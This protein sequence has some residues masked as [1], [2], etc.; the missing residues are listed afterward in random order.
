MNQWG[1]L[2]GLSSKHTGLLCHLS[3]SSVTQSCLTLCNPMDCS[4]PGL[5]VYHHLSAF[6]QTHVHWV[7]Y[8]VQP[9]LPLSSTSLP[10]LNL[11]QHQDLF[12]WVSSLNQVVNVIQLQHQSLQWIFG[13]DFL[14]DGL[15]GSPCHP[16]DSQE[17][18]LIPQFKSIKYSVL[19]FLYSPTHIDAWL[20][21][22]T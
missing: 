7:C 9:S 13:T 11:S 8:A 5:P 1:F 15:V 14:Q 21:E 2:A 12:K 3:V 20:L 4:T 16:R 22:K 19:S 17:S 10:T 6:T 18:F